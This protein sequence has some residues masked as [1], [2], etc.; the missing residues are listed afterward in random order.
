MIHQI[1]TW[2]MLAVPTDSVGVLLDADFHATAALRPSLPGGSA[3][4]GQVEAY[5]ENWSARRMDPERAAQWQNL[6]AMASVGLRARWD[7]AK[8]FV[9]LPLRRDF[10][11][12]RQDPSGANLVLSPEELDI[13]IPYEGWISW[14]SARGL[15][16]KAGRFRQ[17]YSPSPFGVVLGSNLLHDGI[18]AKVPLGRWTFDWFFSSLNPWLAGT[19]SDG[20]VD[21]GSEAYLQ[22]MRSVTNQRGRIYADPYKSLFLHRLTC[23]VGDWDLTIGEQ[24]IVAG[25]APEWRHAVPFVVWHNNYG[26]GYSKVST[27]LQA[28]WT[29]STVH[30]FHFQGIFEDVRVPVG[31]VQ[32]ADPRVVYA[33]NAGWTG[34]ASRASGH[35]S[36][37]LDLTSTSATFNNHTIPLLKGVSRRLYRSNNRLQDRPEFVDTWIVDQPLGYSRGSDAID[38][39]TRLDWVSLD[40]TRGAGVEVDWLNQGDAAVWMDADGLQ[41]RQ[42]PVSGLVTTQVRVLPRAWMDIFRP[43][44]LEAGAGAVLV[45]SPSG[46]SI[47]PV[48]DASVSVRF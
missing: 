15:S 34:R 16:L 6:P 33:A 35:W 3:D 9:E 10:D 24:L 23:K 25:V 14:T 11:A 46:R 48:L 39:W 42:G 21:T 32:G 8:I 29:P 45:D 13:N 38:L 28:I 26:D 41:R 2:L 18:A 20:A 36:A 17:S 7:S 43:I 47:D 5:S 19:K 44:R 12:W 27:H 30:R 1:L 22:R 40:S 31:E 37:S 4:L